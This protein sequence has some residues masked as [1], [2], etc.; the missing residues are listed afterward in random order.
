MY[1]IVSRTRCI[2]TSIVVVDAN[3]ELGEKFAIMEGHRCGFDE[4]EA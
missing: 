1:A 2:A 4:L 3:Q